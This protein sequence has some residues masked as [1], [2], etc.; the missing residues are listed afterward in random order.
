MNRAARL[1]DA[2]AS[3]MEVG[4]GCAEAAGPESK[5]RGGGTGEAAAASA[6]P[7]GVGVTLLDSAWLNRTTMN[8][9]CAA[10]LN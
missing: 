7:V 5:P 10:Q 6:A 8:R 4:S 1:E 2:S 3:A 9:R